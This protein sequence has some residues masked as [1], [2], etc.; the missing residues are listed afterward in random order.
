[1]VF[2]TSARHQPNQLLNRSSRKLAVGRSIHEKRKNE[3][4]KN[5]SNDAHFPSLRSQPSYS[6]EVR[7][8]ST[9]I[10]TVAVVQ[11]VGS[12]LNEHLTFSI[13]NPS[14]LFRIVS[15]NEHLTFSILN[16]SPLFRMVS[17]NEHLTFS[18]QNPLPLF[19]MVSL[20]LRSSFQ[21]NGGFVIETVSPM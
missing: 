2:G 11:V 19:Q 14:P 18:I 15:I 7:E 9:E 20:L 5:S 4:P 8:N 3:N 10:V 13:L 21:N 1:M 6:A 16:S 12:R 17:I